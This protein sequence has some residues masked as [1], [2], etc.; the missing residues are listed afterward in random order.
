MAPSVCRMAV[1]T[2]TLGGFAIV[3]R[4]V[5]KTAGISSMRPRAFLRLVC[6]ESD[7]WVRRR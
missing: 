7:D 3:R 1:S 2:L 4:A 5:V 6:L